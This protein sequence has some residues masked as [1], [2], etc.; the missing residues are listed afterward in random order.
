MARTITYGNLW[1]RSTKAPGEQLSIDEARRRHDERERY[2]AI[3]EDDGMPVVAIDITFRPPVVD[4]FFLDEHAQPEG[5]YKFVAHPDGD[6]WLE[7]TRR[8]QFHAGKIRRQDTVWTRPNGQIRQEDRIT[9]E[10]GGQAVTQ[11][12]ESTF[13][14]AEHPE[15][16]EPMPRFGD[17]GSIARWER[18]A[19]T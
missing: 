2:C 14:P 17:Y 12:T 1:N 10:T 19:S 3:L 15:L 13:D 9:H 6:L 8:R 18:T 7:Q 16:R 11:A 5:Q 4:V